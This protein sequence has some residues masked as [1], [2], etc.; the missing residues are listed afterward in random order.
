MKLI[1]IA[2]NKKY[3][4]DSKEWIKDMLSGIKQ[5]LLVYRR[6]MREGVKQG[7]LEEYAEGLYV[8]NFIE[9]FI[10]NHFEE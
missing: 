4:K 6:Q 9:W 7:N 2:R 10:D 5:D 8:G 3:N 1:N